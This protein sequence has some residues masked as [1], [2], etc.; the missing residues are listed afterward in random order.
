MN[1]KRKYYQRKKKKEEKEEKAASEE[2][3][4]LNRQILGIT[5][6]TPSFPVTIQGFTT[7]DPKESASR[8]KPVKKGPEIGK[9]GKYRILLPKKTKQTEVPSTKKRKQATPARIT[10]FQQTE[11]SP[12]PSPAQIKKTGSFLPLK[13]K[14]SQP[15]PHKFHPETGIYYF[16][17]IFCI[18]RAADAAST[19]LTSVFL[20]S[21]VFVFILLLLCHFFSHFQL[22]FVKSENIK[23]PLTF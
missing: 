15:K 8:T 11:D 3:K 22:P 7:G 12:Q 4:A 18:T 23:R 1:Q 20:S 5:E 14:V 13:T 9:K 10:Q 19:A 16:L 2:E 17:S 21:T 6:D